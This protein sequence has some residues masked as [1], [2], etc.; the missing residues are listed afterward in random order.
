MSYNH[1]TIFERKML[2]K[3]QAQ[4]MSYRAIELKGATPIEYQNLVLEKV[5]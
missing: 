2:L 3:F 1:L 4:G 5:V